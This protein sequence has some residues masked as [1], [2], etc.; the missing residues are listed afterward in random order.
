MILRTADH[1][2]VHGRRFRE[3][4]VK[5]RNAPEKISYLP[6][7][8]L[9]LGYQTTAELGDRDID[10]VYEPFVLFF[11]RLEEYKGVETLLTAWHRLRSSSSSEGK[12]RQFSLV[13]AGE[14]RL[15]DRFAKRLPLGIEIR[16]GRIEDAEAMDLFRRCSLV[17]LPYTSSTQSALVAAAYRF[18]KP[19]LITR[20][21]ALPEYVL[22]GET[23]FIVE[24]DDPQA[25]AF[26]LELAMA[27]G[28]RL[29]AMG[30]AGRAWYGQHRREETADLM[31]L[32]AR[33]AGREKAPVVADGSW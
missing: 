33:Y 14:G 6:L 3:E 30:Q 7:L 15:P 24:P 9:F 29:W 20:T 22:E 19:V 12:G 28:G 1:I 11:G 32:Y 25:L 10:V 18:S 13:M 31:S 4:L 27:D 23:G 26:A 5:K 21:G 16:A 8:H 2:L 17:V